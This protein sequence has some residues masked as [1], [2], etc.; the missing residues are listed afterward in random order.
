VSNSAEY[1]KVS[2]EFI[3]DLFTRMVLPSAKDWSYCQH[4]VDKLAK[5]GDPCAFVWDKDVEDA[6]R[7]DLRHPHKPQRYDA[8]KSFAGS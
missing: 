5:E 2:N 4:M 8:Y 1:F 3:V 6:I 7:G